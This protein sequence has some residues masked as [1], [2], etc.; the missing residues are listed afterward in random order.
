MSGSASHPI[1]RHVAVIMDGNGRWA[2]ARGLPRV[3]GHREGAKAVRR[4]IEAAIDLG[5]SYLT[6]FAFSSENWRRPA[7]EVTDLTFLLKHYLRGELNEMH[8]QGVQL[9]VI[10]ERERFGPN[11]AGELET[12][13]T[14][15]AANTK[16]TLVMALSYGG[17]ADIVAAAR[18]AMQAG[19]QP[20]ELTEQVFAGFLSTAGIP[21]PD[22]LIRT[23]GEERIS[24]F[25][26]WQLAYAELV[27][28]PVL[29]PDFGPKDFAEALSEYAKRERRF[30][31][32]PV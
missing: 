11:L 8:E 30:G 13:E 4:I 27:F 17:R 2:A 16:L 29:W 10:G 23:S 24:N 26:L 31:A 22:L 25:L 21:D 5:V 9:K 12:A 20:E 32:R 3:A 1:P 14:K 28:T 15:T 19:V 6:L 18:R 7:E